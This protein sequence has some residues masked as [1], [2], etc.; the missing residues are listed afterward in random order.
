MPEVRF[1]SATATA[2]SPL[3]SAK[4][5]TAMAMVAGTTIGVVVDRDDPAG[6]R[7]IAKKTCAAA[8][9]EIAGSAMLNN[10]RYSRR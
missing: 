10:V 2:L 6:V 7:A 4:N 3:F 8:H 1:S 5:T 9:V